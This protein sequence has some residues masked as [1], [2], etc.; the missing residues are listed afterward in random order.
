M[1]SR[2]RVI[3]SINHQ[4]PDK[5]PIDFCSAT[6]TGI[7]VSVMDDLRR[8]LKLPEK[9]VKI[10]CPFQMLAYMED[11]MRELLKID[12]AGVVNPYNK[13]GVKNDAFKPFA[14]FNGK[15]A[16]ISKHLAYTQ[17]SEGNIYA[18]PQGDIT[19]KPSAKMPYKGYY[20][21]NI[22]REECYNE[23]E[24]DARED[25]KNTFAEFRDEVI[26]DMEEQAGNL[27]NNTNYAITTQFGQGS[28]GEPSILPGP[29]EK[30]PKGIR[31]FD[32]WLMALYIHRGYI[33]EAY[34]YQTEVALKNLE[35]YRQAFGNKIQIIQLS[36]TDFGTQNGLF[37][38]REIYKEL[39]QPYLKRMIDW[40]HKN[41]QWKV[42]FHTCG[43]IIELME[44][45]I[46]TGVDIVNPVQCSAKDM[47]PR[48]LKNRF[49]DRIVFHGAG[50]NTQKTLPF[51]TPEEVEAEVCERLRIFGKNGG[52]IFCSI[53][54]IQYGSPAENV[55]RLFQAVHK[56]NNR[57]VR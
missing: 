39:Y 50:I 24:L 56:F 44:D 49:G 23:D 20:F 6:V 26:R 15:A 1:T 52:Y 2:E 25:F 51:G 40:I 13:F 12:I 5:I 33:E 53:H 54:N 57:C 55:L 38:S 19:V 30:F 16:E 17:D 14:L 32:D 45:L 3:A 41:T 35:K 4:T 29:A 31:K 21:D 48:I 8:I 11:D 47:D 46:D 7:N 42:F 28:L 27:Y 37:F 34:G 36:A 10:F 22:V 43:S 9:T 18:Y